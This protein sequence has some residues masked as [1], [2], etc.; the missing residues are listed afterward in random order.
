MSDQ[1]VGLKS[2]I[3]VDPRQS[4]LYGGYNNEYL[5]KKSTQV[6]SPQVFQSQTCN[7]NQVQFQVQIPSKSALVDR[8][9]II[10]TSWLI[11]V[12]GA[13]GDGNRLIPT[14]DP[15]VAGEA[16]AY[17][18]P[19]NFI[20]MRSN[21]LSACS[22][23]FTMYINGIAVSNQLS[24]WSQLFS[25]GL[26]SQEMA[27]QLS[28]SYSYGDKSQSY[29]GDSGEY[30]LNS[31]ISPFSPYT[32]SDGSVN[33]RGDGFYTIVSNPAAVGSATITATLRATS[34]EPIMSP[35]FM[36]L[37]RN[38]LKALGGINLLQLN[39]SLG[40]FNLEQALSMPPQ[41]GPVFEI[42]TLG[43][44][45]ESANLYMTI[46][47]PTPLMGPLPSH[48]LYDCE[49]WTNFKSQP[50]ANVP[51]S[52]I[53]QLTVPNVQ[54]PAIPSRLLVWVSKTNLT[55]FGTSPDLATRLNTAVCNT[56]CLAR[57]F[58]I[59]VQFNNTTG[60]WSA[61]DPDG[62]LLWQAAYRNGL[63]MS[64][65]DW[66]KHRGSIAIFDFSSDIPSNALDAVGV[67]GQ[68]NLSFKIE[69]QN[70]NDTN[71]PLEDGAAIPL[72][73][74]IVNYC[75]I[76]D[77]VLEITPTYTRLSNGFDRS[78]VLRDI[79][80][81]NVSTYE[82]EFAN[83][84]SLIG[85]AWYNNMADFK[86]ALVRGLKVLNQHL[87]QAQKAYNTYAAPFLPGSVNSAVNSL[88][89]VA[90]ILIPELVGKGMGGKQI[91]SMFKGQLPRERVEELIKMSRRGGAKINPKHLAY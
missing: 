29:D 5:I 8:R 74:Y 15:T 21:P 52:S 47:T 19:S 73:S 62:Y 88:A 34:F 28:G 48:L 3:V 43:V 75:V 54:L 51:T 68:Y 38:D 14:T 85:S 16:G 59:D 27:R 35:P 41:S 63:E 66:Q 78:Q 42:D 53:T 46:M 33:Y 22:N 25:L 84:P 40:G 87:P 31:S 86:H 83:A 11:T 57:I 23:N 69:F 32:N 2:T 56:D 13:P 36:S 39:Y 17:Y 45:L 10:R 90:S 79:N 44:L 60:I 76:Y 55:S 65:K 89:S 71:L 7:N 80:D 81:G 30:A 37:P 77:A 26:Y 18:D 58:K 91:H 12:T 4:L 1:L 64:F 61:S 6:V 50:V 49:Q 82:V 20:V 9:A 24:D 67:S 70:V 72:Y